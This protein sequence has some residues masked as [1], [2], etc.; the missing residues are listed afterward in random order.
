MPEDGR[1]TSSGIRYKILS[2][3]RGC[4]APKPG[5]MIWMQLEKYDPDG[6]VIFSTRQ[7]P[8]FEGGVEMAVKAPSFNGDIMEVF[9]LMCAGDSAIVMIAVDSVD[10]DSPV[11]KDGQDKWYTYYLKLLRALSPDDHARETQFA[12]TA[13]RY[14]DSI[15][16]NDW[17]SFNNLSQDNRDSNG[18]VWVFTERD[19]TANRLEPGDSVSVH[20]RLKLI[21]NTLIDDSYSRG[22]PFTFV[23]GRGEVIKGWDIGLLQF[24]LKEKGSLL[25]PSYLAYGRQGSG[26]EI[27]PD[28]VLVFQIE[29]VKVFKR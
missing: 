27:P 26:G 19:S 6:Q 8:F 21:D 13:S 9:T 12:L 23:L 7:D 10:R 24:G 1:W 25:I 2:S 3:H 11:Y 18:I 4:N 22:I 17:L 16:I 14:N 15:L 28:A 20:Y 29:I 5:D